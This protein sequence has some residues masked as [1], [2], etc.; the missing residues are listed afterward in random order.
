MHPVSTQQVTPNVSCTFKPL[1]VQ[2]VFCVETNT[3]LGLRFRYL[4][5]KNICVCFLLDLNSPLPPPP[6]R[7]PQSF[8]FLT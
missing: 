1:C 7:P 8:C 3:V 2:F 4:L 5:D 6:P